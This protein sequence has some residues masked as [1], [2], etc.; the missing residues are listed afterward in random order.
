MV[1]TVSKALHYRAS[2]RIVGFRDRL[3]V[4]HSAPRA[5]KPVKIKV[6]GEV[7]TG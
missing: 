6:E 3:S 5:G 4:E 7:L 2:C 1:V